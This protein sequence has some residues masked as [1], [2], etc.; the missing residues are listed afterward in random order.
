MIHQRQL[1]IVESQVEEAKARGARVL[2][3]GTRL[4]DLGPNFY[5][6][7]ILADVNR[8][9]LI[10][11]EETFGPVLPLV[12]FDSEEEAVG[13]AND[14][15]FGLGASVWTRDRARGEALA[16]RINAGTVLVNDVVCG[17]GI[18][19]APHGGVKQSGIGST[20]GRFGLEEMVRI[21]YVSS[22]RLHGLKRVWWYRYG[23]RFTRHIEALLDLQFAS[24]PIRRLRAALRSLGP[25]LLGKSK[26]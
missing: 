16:R 2:C 18:S 21:K 24:S 12:P 15:E 5:A 7:T 14:S 26:L 1:R 4:P 22:E 8:D 23:D 10:M 11:R 13:M 20:H 9:M 3:G 17:F 25:H 6:P 19:E